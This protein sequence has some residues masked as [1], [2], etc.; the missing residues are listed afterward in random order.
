[1]GE[2]VFRLGPSRLRLGGA[3][4]GKKQTGQNDNDGD[5]NQQLDESEGALSSGERTRPRVLVFAPH[6]NM[7]P[8][9]SSR[10]R[11]HDREHAERVRSPSLRD[12]QTSG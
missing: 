12:P 7:L 10:S 6:Q 1:L 2:I 8:G 9:K 4:C 11:G 3:E 5:N